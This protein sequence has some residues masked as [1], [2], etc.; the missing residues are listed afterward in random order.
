MNAEERLREREMTLCR[1]GW[2]YEDERMTRTAG[3]RDPLDGLL[4]DAA[5]ALRV[6]T[7]RSS[8]PESLVDLAAAAEQLP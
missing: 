2:I 3:W 5:S 4:H 8:S 7:D 1:Y 6:E